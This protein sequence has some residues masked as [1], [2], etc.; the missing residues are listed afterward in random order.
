MVILTILA[1]SATSQGTSD[2]I[3]LIW[4]VSSLRPARERL[5]VS[6]LLGC[7]KKGANAGTGELLRS[8]CTTVAG[9][10]ESLC[11]VPRT[12]PDAVYAPF[13]SD[14]FVSLVGDS[15]RVPVKILRDTGASESLIRQ[16]VLAFSPA[17]DTGSAVLI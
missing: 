12:V 3:V 15:R 4:P 2:V 11:V 10:D 9:E 16:A 7:H 6:P 14:G 13:V 8:G 1:V 5:V 17:S